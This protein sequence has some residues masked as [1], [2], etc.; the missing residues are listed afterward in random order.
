MPPTETT[1]GATV[2]VF[3]G[4]VVGPSAFALLAAATGRFDIGYMVVAGFSLLGFFALRGA[5]TR[6]TSAR[7][8]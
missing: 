5:G 1:A 3:M 2:V 8:T 4:Y 6:G 7:R